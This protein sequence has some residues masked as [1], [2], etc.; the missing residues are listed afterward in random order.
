MDPE[1]RVDLSSFNNSWYSPGASRIRVIAW[2]FVNHLVV[3]NRLLPFS[4]LKIAALR[5]FG[6]RIGKGVFIKP[7]VRVKYP[8]LLE[9]G[10]YVWIGEDV[11]IDNLAQVTINDHVC[12]SQGAMLL[13]G[14]HNYRSASFDL[15]V[16]PIHLE[17][18]VWIGAQAVVC[19][20]VQCKKYSLLAVGSVATHQ[21][22]E[23]GIYQG[24]PAL[25]KRERFIEK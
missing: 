8:W 10:N 1:P 9:I 20:G 12:L 18:G 11:W 2:Y 22:K 6:A 25:L 7:G 23:N 16:K 15:L 19:P 4:G 14:S 24:N 21:L 5:A 17:K 13:C 3:Y